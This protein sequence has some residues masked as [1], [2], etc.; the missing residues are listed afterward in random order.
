LESH[1]SQLDDAI[2]SAVDYRPA[3]GSSRDELSAGLKV[4]MS[5]HQAA[6]INIGIFN[7]RLDTDGSI[8]RRLA[9]ALIAALPPERN[10][11]RW[12]YIGRYLEYLS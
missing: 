1:I 8:A 6:G 4:L 11:P 7:P 10:A 12:E 9:A 5:L 3:G 2:M